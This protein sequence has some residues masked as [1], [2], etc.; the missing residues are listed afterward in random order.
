VPIFVANAKVKSNVEEIRDTTSS[1]TCRAD[2]PN[3]A[4]QPFTGL[5]CEPIGNV[6]VQLAG[7][8]EWTLV[9]PEYWKWLRP[10]VSPDSRGFFA[11][12]APNIDHVP[13]YRLRTLPGDAL[14]V[15]PWTWHR[16]DYGLVENDEEADSTTT[17]SEDTD[18]D[19]TISIGAS[20]FH[21]RPV[22][23]VKRNPIYATLLA[24]YLFGELIGT[25]TQ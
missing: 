18:K 22:E 7:A 19:T 9:Q 6:S 5:H 3:T 13:R 15:P 24:P 2:H 8:R 16:V 20:L 23:F 11:S 4:A 25:K 12:W 14:W 17:A 10:T 21:F 1:N